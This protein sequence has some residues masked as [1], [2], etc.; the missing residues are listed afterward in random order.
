M[1]KFQF[2]AQAVLDLRRRHEESVKRAW[3]DAVAADERAQ[4]ELATAARGYDA[5]R[6]DAAHVHDA[7]ARVWHR[8]W[9]LGLEQELARAKG[10]AQ[11]RRVAV[12]AAL[13]SLN[14]AHRDVRVLERLYDRAH[15]AW[16]Q[17]QCRA[18]QKE[19]DWLGCIQHAMRERG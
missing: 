14:L 9:I 4:A 3:A 12:D 10:L 15:A 7:A 6:D 17:A 18:E 13:A 1:A 11:T 5:A 16:Q 2:R 19:L 8:N